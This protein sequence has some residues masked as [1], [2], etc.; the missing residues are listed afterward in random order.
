MATLVSFWSLF[1]NRMADLGLIDSKL[2]LYI[3]VNVNNRQ[4]KF[5]VHI[6]KNVSY[7]MNHQHERKIIAST[8]KLWFAKRGVNN[9]DVIIF[10]EYQ[11]VQI[12]KKLIIIHFHNT[13][14][15]TRNR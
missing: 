15:T 3:K 12:G 11:I 8:C 14:K 6:S 1:G 2:G 7:H 5:E 13:V 4:N 10:I 9:T